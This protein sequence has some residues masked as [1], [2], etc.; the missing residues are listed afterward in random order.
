MEYYSYSYKKLSVFLNIS[1][2]FTSESFMEVDDIV[3]EN[4]IWY[5]LIY[6]SVPFL[7]MIYLRPSSM[8]SHSGNRNQ[9]WYLE[10]V[11]HKLYFT[12]ANTCMLI[13]RL[14]FCCCCLNLIKEVY[15][16]H[17]TNQYYLLTPLYDRRQYG[18]LSIV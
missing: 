3:I 2:Q 7:P 14:R 9:C 16:M 10:A 4:F 11:Q 6:Q 12:L 18:S 5:V 8:L 17:F 15:S 13:E 1:F